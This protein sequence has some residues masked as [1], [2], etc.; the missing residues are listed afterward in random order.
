MGFLALIVVV[1][2]VG[3]MVLMI[4]QVLDERDMEGY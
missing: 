1:A 2:A 4:D 3:G